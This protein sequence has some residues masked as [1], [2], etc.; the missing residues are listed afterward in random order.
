MHSALS[1]SALSAGLGKSSWTISKLHKHLDEAHD[2]QHGYRVH[3]SH[4]VR[5][6][7]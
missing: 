6:V 7:D 4:A 3:D 1:R 2:V 5:D